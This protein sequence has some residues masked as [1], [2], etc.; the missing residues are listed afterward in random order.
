MKLYT[1]LFIGLV[2]SVNVNAQITLTSATATPTIGDNFTYLIASAPPISVSQGGA[3]QTWDFTALTGSP[4]TYNYI[5][6]SDASQSNTFP[7]ANIVESATGYEGYAISNSSEYSYAGQF[8]PGSVRVIYTDKRE[9]LKF[10]MTYNDVFNE[11][12]G[13]PVLNI[14]AAQTFYRSGTTQIKAD[15][16]G[17]VILPSGTYTNVLRVRSVAEYSDEYQGIPLYFY[18]DTIYT[19]Y[20][21]LTN[22]FIAGYS[23]GYANGAMYIAAGFCYEPSIPA[24]SV[25]ATSID[26][27][28]GN[29]DGT[30]TATVSG[31][32]SPFTYAWNDGWSQTTA[33]AT[34]LCPGS[35]MVRVTDN[36]GNTATA[37]VT[38]I[39]PT[40]VAA[41]SSINAVK[42]FPNPA[43]DIVKMQNAYE[44]LSLSISDLSGQITMD[45]D[46]QQEGEPEF[47]VADLPKGI[48]IIRWI[49]KDGQHSRKLLVE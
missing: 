5:S 24:L 17:T 11:T 33:T 36:V 48:Y 12:F 38:I 14:A 7:S 22:N 29:C 27:S 49:T 47:S 6:L 2:I 32:T 19:W 1:L 9:F 35:Y 18:N 13:G 25:V 45:I 20:D 30:G 34:G 46:V 39:D 31:G 41:M 44:I 15:G 43:N 37:I 3:N 40:G 28:P 10:P 26:V 16:H 23:V 4:T 8:V 21:G 42:F